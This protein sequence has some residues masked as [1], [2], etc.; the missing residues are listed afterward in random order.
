MSIRW[1]EN[2]IDLFWPGLCLDPFG[3]LKTLL[4]THCWI[5]SGTAES[6]AKGRKDRKENRDEGEERGGERRREYVDSEYAIP[7]TGVR[8]WM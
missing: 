5:Y 6:D 4:Q 3:K 1:T 7:G 8:E 2:N